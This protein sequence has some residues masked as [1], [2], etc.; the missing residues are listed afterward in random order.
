MLL[1]LLLMMLMLLLLLLLLMMMMMMMLLLMLFVDIAMVMMSFSTAESSSNVLSISRTKEARQI[2]SKCKDDKQNIKTPLARQWLMKHN[3]T[4]T[5]CHH[6][7]III[8]IYTS[9]NIQKPLALEVLL[10]TLLHE[11][12]ASHWFVH[13]WNSKIR[14]STTDRRWAAFGSLAK[15]VGCFLFSKFQWNRNCGF[16]V[17]G[18]SCNAQLPSEKIHIPQRPAMCTT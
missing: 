13:G 18:H 16:T 6:T 11:N 1:L 9:K 5:T 2:H 14:T 17:D 12:V 4:F 7:N 15:K 8:Y 3:T 10:E